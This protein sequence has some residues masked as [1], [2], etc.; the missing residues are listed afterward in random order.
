MDITTE[1]SQPTLNKTFDD[2]LGTR[3]LIYSETVVHAVVTRSPITIIGLY[4]RDHLGLSTF[5]AVMVMVC[6]SI[7]RSVA[8]QIN[9]KFLALSV[10][11]SCCA[12]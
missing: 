6:F 12:L 5:A 7:G 2:T 4:A 9:S 1:P 8:I 11:M 10:M 3:L